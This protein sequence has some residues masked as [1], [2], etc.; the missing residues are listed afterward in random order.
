MSFVLQSGISVEVVPDAS[1]QWT[2][3]LGVCGLSL[4]VGPYVGGDEHERHVLETLGSGNWYRSEYDEIRFSRRDEGRLESLWF[5]IPE[6]NME[7]SHDLT[8]WKDTVPVPGG[9]RLREKVSF[10]LD[11]TD[12]RWCSRNGEIIVCMRKSV[13]GLP[14]ERLR[15]RVAPSVDLFIG[16]QR[17]FGWAVANPE[18]FL[19]DSW[20]YL[21]EEAA[22]G[23]LGAL[24]GEYFDIVTS[25]RVIQM[26]D[27]DP[28]VLEILKSLDGKI[29]LRCGAVARRALLHRCIEETIDSFY[30]T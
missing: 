27:K 30:S 25:Q 23:E 8:A 3:R 26:E 11:P 21:P 6:T 13:H 28:G 15:L 19:T 22:D 9:L 17:L 16:D 4:M 7:S 2:P 18:R 1:L 24:L 14:K 20:S 29:D 12:E 10:T 5:H